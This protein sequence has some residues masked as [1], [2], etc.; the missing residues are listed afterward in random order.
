MLTVYLIRLDSSKIEITVRTSLERAEMTSE[1][2]GHNE[3]LVEGIRVCPSE[4]DACMVTEHG[5]VRASTDR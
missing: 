4:F 1:L 2:I 3:E 5:V